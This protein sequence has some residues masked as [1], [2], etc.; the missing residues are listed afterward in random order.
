MLLFV[1]VKYNHVLCVFGYSRYNVRLMK[2]MGEKMNGVTSQALDHVVIFEKVDALAQSLLQSYELRHYVTSKEIMEQ[3]VLA[4]QWRQQ[5]MRAK[6]RFEE[7]QR[8]G[9][10]HP[11]YHEALENMR[12]IERVS[13]EIPAVR[14]WKDAE[15]TLDMLLYRVSQLLAGAVS[16]SIKVPSNFPEV[17]KLSGGCGSGGTCQCG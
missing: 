1:V 11:N 3:D 5:M 13:T 6:E 16:P 12:E 15:V 9:H 2:G 17:G 4:S 7:A 14:T 10:F 8:F